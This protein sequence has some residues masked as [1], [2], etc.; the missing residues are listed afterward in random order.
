MEAE[1]RAFTDRDPHTQPV[2]ELI[3]AF[4]IEPILALFLV[5]FVAP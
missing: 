1:A 4:G 5:R 2:T 3:L